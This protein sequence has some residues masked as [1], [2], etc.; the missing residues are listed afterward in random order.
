MHGRGWSLGKRDIATLL[1]REEGVDSGTLITRVRVCASLAFLALLVVIHGT[2]LTLLEDDDCR[3][4]ANDVFRRIV[5]R[6]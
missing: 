5:M 3:V 1:F 2:L 4:D 6:N